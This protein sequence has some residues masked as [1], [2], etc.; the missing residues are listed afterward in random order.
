M[1][2]LK[3]NFNKNK[4]EVNQVK[5]STLN[6]RLAQQAEQRKQELLALKIKNLKQEYKP[7]YEQAIRTLEKQHKFALKE[8]KQTKAKKHAEPHINK[9]QKHAI[10]QHYKQDKKAL[11][12]EHKVAIENLK[13][14]QQQ[15]IMELA[16]R[17]I[18][19][20]TQVIA[21]ERST[22]HSSDAIPDP[23]QTANMLVIRG[24]QPASN[25]ITG[26]RVSLD[27]SH[28]QAAQPIIQTGGNPY[29]HTL[30]NAP[31]LNSIP[32]N[33]S[34]GPGMTFD[35]QRPLRT[36]VTTDK[37]KDSPYDNLSAEQ[38]ITNAKPLE[39]YL[40]TKT[41]TVDSLDSLKKTA[42]FKGLQAKYEKYS[43]TRKY[44]QGSREWG[45]ADAINQVLEA[46]ENNVSVDE[47]RQ[48][49]NNNREDI[50]KNLGTGLYYKYHLNPLNKHG[51][52][53][54]SAG[55]LRELEQAIGNLEQHH[56]HQTKPNM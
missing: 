4:L 29:T 2:G 32:S 23:A 24:P 28:P 50:E 52:K 49:I 47:L 20:A 8:L 42:A 11:K 19:A 26:N 5:L 40:Q 10:D 44:T 37:A 51:D 45:K 56:S 16:Q 39:T 30:L 53:S 41:R 43:N 31:M 17:A 14:Q 36:R 38:R 18:T 46:I 27:V 7:Q 33:N 55:Y 13:N 25:N 12:R 6:T 3:L 35:T 48:V 9:A 1:P 34:G 21:S 15:E 54:T 22:D